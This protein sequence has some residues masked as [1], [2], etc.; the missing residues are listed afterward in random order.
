MP[1]TGA[2]RPQPG[3]GQRAE[4]KKQLHKALKA[5]KDR[6][7]KTVQT[8][9]MVVQEPASVHRGMPLELLR[10]PLQTIVNDPVAF[11]LN[12]W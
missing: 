5:N 4:E 1:R 6:V 8:L 11:G 2:K 3:D 12:W 7:D 9:M 10:G